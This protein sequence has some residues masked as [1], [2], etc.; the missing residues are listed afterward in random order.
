MQGR[1]HS[2]KQRKSPCLLNATDTF[3]LVLKKHHPGSHTVNINV[4]IRVTQTTVLTLVY[5]L[6]RS[7]AF[8]VVILNGNTTQGWVIKKPQRHAENIF[9]LFCR[10]EREQL[11][12]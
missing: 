4:N 6:G 2:R 7:P 9:E 12:Y 5:R 11:K 1:V 10:P 3:C 8:E